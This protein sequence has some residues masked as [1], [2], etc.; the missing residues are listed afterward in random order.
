LLF[1][2]IYLCGAA[3][4]QKSPAIVSGTV[5]SQ[6]GLG[7]ANVSWSENNDYTVDQYGPTSLTG[8]FSLYLHEFVHSLNV[9]FAQAMSRPIVKIG[10]FTTPPAPTVPTFFVLTALRLVDVASE[11]SIAASDGFAENHVFFTEV[12]RQ[13]VYSRSATSFTAV[14]RTCGAAC[15]MYAF[16]QLI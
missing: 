4:V 2:T 10:D 3:G 7:S 11:A 14:M 9:P 8:A 13:G 16:F 1:L 6:T 15:M 12:H 5:L